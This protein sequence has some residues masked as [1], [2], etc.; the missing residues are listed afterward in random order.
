[1]HT[2][3][4]LPIAIEHL[5]KNDPKLRSVIDQSPIFDREPQH[6]PSACFNSLVRAIVYQQLSGKAAGTIYGRIQE[7][8]APVFTPEHFDQAHHDELRSLGLSNAKTLA[9]KDLSAKVLTN[10]IDLTKLPTMDNADVIEYLVKVKG[11]G[12]WSAQ[13][14]LMFTL[15]RPDILPLADLGIKKGAM[16]VYGLSTLPDA[17]VLLQLQ[18]ANKWSPYSTVASWYLWRSLELDE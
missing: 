12:P 9:L 3:F 4:S 15:V 16:R 1:M 11:I 10:D 2:S 18:S 5:R 13:M 17:S 6:T 7:R 8:F 14:F